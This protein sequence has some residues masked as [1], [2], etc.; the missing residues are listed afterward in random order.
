MDFYRP[1]SDIADRPSIATPAVMERNVHNLKEAP[2]PDVMYE[3][4]QYL[5]GHSDGDCPPDCIDC[6]RL[7]KIRTLLLLPF[8]SDS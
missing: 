3:Q 2:L 7:Q 5:I 4:L 1:L 6:D 8:R